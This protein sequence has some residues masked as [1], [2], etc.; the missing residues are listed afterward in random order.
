[1][2]YGRDEKREEVGPA[3]RKGGGEE[4]REPS[5]LSPVRLV[6]PPCPLFLHTPEPLE[7]L[8]PFSGFP[9]KPDPQDLRAE[10]VR[11]KAL[12]PFLDRQGLFEKPLAAECLASPIED[13][14]RL[15]RVVLAQVK[16]YKI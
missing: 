1:M 14:P 10:I 12:D 9:Q 13:V 15:D 5:G 6:P 7:R 2:R 8:P 11:G 4:P 16:I 3:G